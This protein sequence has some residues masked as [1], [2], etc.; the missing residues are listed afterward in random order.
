MLSFL[1]HITIF[2][3]YNG[4]LNLIFSYLYSVFVHYYFVSVYLYS[5]FDICIQSS[6]IA[7]LYFTCVSNI[8][9]FLLLRSSFRFYITI[10]VL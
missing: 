6:F 7:I 4:G 3:L 1:F 5:L 10:L 8:C 2:V 9:P